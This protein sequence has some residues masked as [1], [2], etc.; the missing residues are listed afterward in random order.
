MS[1]RLCFFFL[2][3]WS[4]GKNPTNTIHVYDIVGGLWACAEWMASVGRASGDS[5]A[6]EEIP[7]YN[8]KGKVEEVAG[9]PPHDQKL[10]APL[11]TLVIFVLSCL[12]VCPLT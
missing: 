8:D 1:T 11:F 12:S 9:M 4:P 6:G 10:V 5:L 2:F 3:S 7:F